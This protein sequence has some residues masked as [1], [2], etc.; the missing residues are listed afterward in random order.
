VIA[1]V[2]G[3]ILFGTILV[4]ATALSPA[5]A[6]RR[7]LLA[8]TPDRSGMTARRVPAL[9]PVRRQLP[10]RPPFPLIADWIA[11]TVIGIIADI[12]SHH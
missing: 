6:H 4:L 10:G 1:V 12:H 9:H 7:K 11:A 3:I 8:V 2:F 5:L